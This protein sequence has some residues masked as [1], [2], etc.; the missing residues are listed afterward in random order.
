MAVRQGVTRRCS[1]RPPLRAAPAAAAPPPRRLLLPLLRA[2][3]LMASLPP[4]FH[5]METTDCGG[6]ATPAPPRGAE[7]TSMAIDGG[8]ATPDAVLP[9][10]WEAALAS[11]ATAA[12]QDPL[13]PETWTRAQSHF[14]P[15]PVLRTRLVRSRRVFPAKPYAKHGREGGGGCL[16]SQRFEKAGVDPHALEVFKT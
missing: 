2:L 14:K 11:A 9:P 15:C 8:A 6:G 5:A 10:F 16:L 3:T 13:F 12:D 7:A 1:F 4:E